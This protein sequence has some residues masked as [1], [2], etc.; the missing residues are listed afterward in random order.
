MRSFLTILFFERQRGTATLDRYAVAL[1]G[2]RGKFVCFRK[3]KISI[4][5]ENRDVKP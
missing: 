5:K 3:E 2:E 1:F 4:E